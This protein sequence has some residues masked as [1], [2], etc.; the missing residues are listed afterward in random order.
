[1]GEKIGSD[2]NS[3]QKVASLEIFG[4]WEGGASL[5]NCRF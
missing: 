2:E 3:D 4:R 5:L 1:V